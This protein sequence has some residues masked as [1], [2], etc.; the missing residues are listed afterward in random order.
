MG[1]VKNRIE[2]APNRTKNYKLQGV[3]LVE[4]DAKVV[5]WGADAIL[6]FVFTHFNFPNQQFY[7]AKRYIHATEEGEEDILFVLADSV[8]PAVRSGGIGP[9]AVDENNH[10]DGAEANNAPILLSGRTSNISSEDM[11]ELFRQGIDIN[12]DNDPAPDNV[13]RQGETTTGTGNWRR[14]GIIFP[15]KSG[16]LQNILAS[17]KH[18]SHD[19]ILRMSLLQ[20]FLVIFP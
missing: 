12:D 13:P 2:L 5:R 19:A 14:E 20:L 11:V 10:A 1:E 7:A 16:N 18:Y 3:V 9:L 17:F 6:V 15:R 4:V 8:I